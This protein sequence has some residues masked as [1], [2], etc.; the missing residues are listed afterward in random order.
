[1]S[2][3]H[4][5][6]PGSKTRQPTGRQKRAKKN[7][8][9]ASEGT[10]SLMCWFLSPNHSLK[11]QLARSQSGNGAAGCGAGP[12][13][14]GAPANGHPEPGS[15]SRGAG[16]PAPPAAAGDGWGLRTGHRGGC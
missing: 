1:M 10:K 12:A 9:V 8:S 7:C 5:H 6:L 13:G 15:A 16:P 2:P 14:T 3:G 4:T 11:K